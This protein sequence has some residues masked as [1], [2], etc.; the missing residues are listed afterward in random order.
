MR[1]RLPSPTE[2]TVLRLLA[3]L[4]ETYGLALVEA[5]GGALKRGGI[6]VLLDRLGAKGFVESREE[7]HP[8][9]GYVGIPRKLYRVSSTGTQALRAEEAMETML[10]G[11]ALAGSIAGLAPPA[12][13]FC[14]AKPGRPCTTLRGRKRKVHH[15]QRQLVQSN[16]VSSRARAKLQ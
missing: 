6:Y 10:S 14:G 16:V 11:P 12:C 13:P 2:S 15:Q 7:S 4:G 9:D 3:K 8:T 5:S 1:V